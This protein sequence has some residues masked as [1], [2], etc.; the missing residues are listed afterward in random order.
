MDLKFRVA[1]RI[2]QPGARGVRGGRRPRHSCRTIS[3]PAAPRAGSRPARPSP[4]TSTISRA[5]SRSRWSRSCPTRRSCSSGKPNEGEPP[6]VETQPT[7]RTA[8]NYQT[9]VTMTL[10]AARRRHPDPGR[11]QGGRLAREPGRARGELRQLP[12]LVA[13]ALRAQGLGRARHQ[14][15]RGH[16]QIATQHGRAVPVGTAVKLLR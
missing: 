13:D 7:A 11:D 6:N 3:P 10:H 9:T 1:A 14:P 8:A 2:A 4:G 15:A 12:G 5:P 16:V